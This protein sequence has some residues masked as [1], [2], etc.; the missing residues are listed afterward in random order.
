ALLEDGCAVNAGEFVI[1]IASRNDSS[2]FG[3]RGLESVPVITQRAYPGEHNNIVF[4]YPHISVGHKRKLLINNRCKND[5][6]YGQGKLA[7]H[8]HAADTLT[9]YPGTH[10]ALQ[11]LHGLEG[12]QVEGGIAP[13]KTTYDNYEPDKQCHEARV[14]KGIHTEFLSGE[15]VKLLQRHVA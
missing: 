12:S 8:Q 6:E 5:Q 4:I 3:K 2:L 13:R 7:D 10:V 15:N 11:A 1:C 9:L 14:K